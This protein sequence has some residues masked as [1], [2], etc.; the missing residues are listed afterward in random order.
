MIRI[1]LCDDETAARDTLRFALEKVL[2]EETEE[3]VYEFVSGKNAANWL[4]KHP[5][6]IDLLFLDVE[7]KEPDGME[8]AR[9][10]RSFDQEL[11]IVFVTGHRDYVFAGY[12]TGAL[13]YI[14]KPAAP[15]KLK[16][17]MER[18]RT[19]LFR[20]QEQ[21]FVFRN[22]DGTYRMPLERILYFYSDRRKIT[23]VT[24]EKE[25]PFYGKMDE[26]QMALGGSFVRIHQR[27]L[28]NARKVEH[29][30]KNEVELRGIR[31]PVSRNMR[32][33]AEAA[34]A[35]LILEENQ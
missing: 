19:I 30:G 10:I 12:E 35:R 5:G 27:Y 26:V 31:L 22:T 24:G 20:N 8:T 7:M 11:L 15:E 28:V 21:F 2:Q 17:V 9:L 6:E 3:I 16:Q 4:K 1:G 32:P 13:D 25:Y 29:I 18:A 34:F 14:L 33:E 23:A